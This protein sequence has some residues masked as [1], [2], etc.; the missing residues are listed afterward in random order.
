MG[1]LMGQSVYPEP[2]VTS[3]GEMVDGVQSFGGAYPL[4]RLSV[5]Q[6]MSYNVSNYVK[7]PVHQAC[8]IEASNLKWCRLLVWVDVHSMYDQDDKHSSRRSALCVCS[9]SRRNRGVSFVLALRNHYPA[10]E[11]DEH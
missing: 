3:S 6:Y 11:Q 5:S 2:S 10:G 1:N 9:T 8:E 4:L 7:Y